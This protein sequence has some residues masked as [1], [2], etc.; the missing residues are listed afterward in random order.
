MSTIRDP[1]ELT[2]DFRSQTFHDDLYSN[3]SNYLRETP[4]FKSSEGVV[5]VTRYADCVAL[6][7]NDTFCRAPPTGG[8]NPFSPAQRDQSPLEIMISHWML[9]MDPPRHETVR[10]AFL[11]FFTAES[12]RRIEPS[13]RRIANQLIEEMP[14]DGAVE[15]LQA[16]AFPLPVMV[17]AELLGVPPADIDMFRFWSSQLTRAL[18]AGNEADILNGTAVSLALRDYFRDMMREAHSLPKHSLMR[19]LSAND[20]ISLSEDE[21]LYGCA[22]LLWAGHET[23]KNLVASGI[24]VLAER[25]AD[26][27][28]LQQEPALID[29]TIEEILRFE[30]PVQKISR[31]SCKDYRFGDVLIPAGTL[32]TALI[33]AANRDPAVFVAPDSFDLR[34]SR[35]R[36]IGFGHGIHHCLGAALSR[37]EARI[38]L[39][40]LVPR[41]HQLELVQH[42][43]RTHSAF[44]SLES[45][46][47]KIVLTY[48]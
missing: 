29:S 21:L 47:A 42:Q 43:W 1:H 20:A 4:V 22:F 5:Y 23:T 46:H 38:A 13:I 34:R 15:F 39:G 11:P 40:A 2:P 27:A 7:S 44:R 10:R 41:L 18:D 8:C 25:P 6:L 26:L 12:V 45:L 16:Y 48:K 35:N 32:V 37:T 9:F 24:F 3:Y 14:Q 33:G 30:S 36:H 31:W 17:I 19:E 28:A